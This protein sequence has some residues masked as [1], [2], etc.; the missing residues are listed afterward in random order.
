MPSFTWFLLTLWLSLTSHAPVVKS[1]QLKKL[2]RL[3]VACSVDGIGVEIVY[4][5]AKLED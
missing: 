4:V 5:E 1:I 3:K 2:Q